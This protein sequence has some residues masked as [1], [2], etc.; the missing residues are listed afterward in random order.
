[1]ISGDVAKD[2]VDLLVHAVSSW[3]YINASGVDTLRTQRILDDES[4]APELP[5][6]PPHR[7]FLAREREISIEAA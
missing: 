2:L 7:R 4:F 6:F 5:I 1:M 3:P